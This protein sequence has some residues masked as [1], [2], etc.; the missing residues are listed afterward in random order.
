MLASPSFNPHRQLIFST[1]TVVGL[2]LVAKL[3]GA[4]K[5]AVM[6]DGMGASA[7][8]DQFV[9]A[10]MVATWPAAV[11]TSVLTIALTPVLARLQPAAASGGKRQAQFLAQLWCAWTALGALLALAAWL[12]FP[13]LSP[14]AAAGGPKL[15]AAVGLVS[16]ISCMTALVGTVLT[17][18]GRQIGALLEGLP[19]LV[20]G[21]LMLSSVWAKADTL[22]YG[23]VLGTGLQLLW[24]LAANARLTVNLPGQA[25]WAW[26]QPSAA[27]KDFFSGLGYASAGY[28][29]LSAAATIGLVVASRMGEGS[30]ASLNY[31]SR[32][33]AL[34]TG[35]LATAVNRVAIVHFCGKN[36]LDSN[37]WRNWGS[38]AAA[39]TLAA[40]V[41]SAVLMVL[42]PQIVAGLFE[43]GEFKAQ[44]TELVSRLL[45][46]HVSQLTPFL[47]SVVL[48]AYLSAT[49]GFRTLFIACLL[50]FLAELM[51]VMVGVEIW[52][53]DAIA[54]APM[55]GRVAMTGY[56][57]MALLMRRG[58]KPWPI[59][60]NSST[61]PA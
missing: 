12:S 41:A 55:V 24:L 39:F 21:G 22:I 27:W 18:R 46:W 44:E 56:L 60:T 32:I 48:C 10:F 29:L 30:L 45:R 25:K 33:T 3:S 8:M 37:D 35:L 14:V 6:A 28:V 9:F 49:G 19:S 59:T 2:T 47:A 15:A 51:M 5:E 42:A 50:C 31:A 43:R 52:G 34:L 20:L 7:L 53:L 36:A 58:S 23:L 16:F 11:L 13:Y 26:P 1:L 57:L 17:S 54:A 4:F 61:F 40:A 38:V